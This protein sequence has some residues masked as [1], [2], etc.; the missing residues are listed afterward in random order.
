MHF[1]D[2]YNEMQIM[3][4]DVSTIPARTV[5][6]VFWSYIQEDIQ[7]DK[8]FPFSIYEVPDFKCLPLSSNPKQSSEK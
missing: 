1:T 4:N 3:L 7:E 5:T 8:I 6:K 2:N